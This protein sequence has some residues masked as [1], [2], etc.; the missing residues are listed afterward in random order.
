MIFQVRIRIKKFD[1]VYRIN[2]P[3]DISESNANRLF[4]FGTAENGT[5]RDSFV[6]STLKEACCRDNLNI[7]T[8]SNWSKIGFLKAGFKEKNIKVIPH[9]IEPS[10]FYKSDY[11]DRSLTRKMLNV[12]SD[13][14]LLLNLG[15]LTDNKGVDLLLAAYIS[16]KPKYSNLRLKWN[17]M[18]IYLRNTHICH[19]E[20]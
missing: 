2:F 11:I 16:L 9:G 10:V 20:Q 5:T 12:K 13:D 14:F 19:N 3:L 4:V 15:A 17:L 1:V 18:S 8:P 7:V 6:G